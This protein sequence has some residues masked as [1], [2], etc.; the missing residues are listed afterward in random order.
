MTNLANKRK[1]VTSQ[2]LPFWSQQKLVGMKIN[3]Y[4]RYIASFKKFWWKL[5]KLYQNKIYDFPVKC[6]CEHFCVID[7]FCKVCALL[8]RSQGTFLRP[9]I[10]ILSNY[11]EIHQE[12][13]KLQRIENYEW[14]KFAFYWICFFRNWK[15]TVL[16]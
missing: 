9:H 4:G 5:K 16:C 11:I 13:L 1:I 8:R 2:K 6:P 14:R 12:L 7:E 3:G 15:K 10:I